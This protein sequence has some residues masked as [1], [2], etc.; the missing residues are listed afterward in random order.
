[1]KERRASRDD[2]CARGQLV[3]RG[4]GGAHLHE[5]PEAR[6][7]MCSEPLGIGGHCG[8]LAGLCLEDHDLP[9]DGDGTR[10]R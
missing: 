5:I 7:D 10:S 8:R 4:G 2:T 9:L 1:V 6:L 3:Q